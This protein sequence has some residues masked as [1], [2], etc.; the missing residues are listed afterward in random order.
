MRSGIFLLLILLSAI[1]L[2]GQKLKYKDIQEQLLASDSMTIYPVLKAFI[3]QDTGHAHA[4][5]TLARIFSGLAKK[6]DPIREFNN[7]IK[8]S[9]SALFYFSKCKRLLTEKEIRKNSD[10]YMFL[11]TE[12]ERKSKDDEVILTNKITE[13]INSHILFFQTHLRNIRLIF[14]CFSRASENYAFANTHYVKINTDFNS[15]KELYLIAGD[16]LKTE[17]RKIGSSYDSTLTYLNL[18]KKTLTDYPIKNF[19]PSYEV[20]KIE[21]FRLDGLSG[22]EF[23][24]DKILLWN[25]SEWT[26]AF[27][28]II[29]SDI[30]SLREKIKVN[31]EKLNKTASLLSEGLSDTVSLNKMDPGLVM[32]LNKY[33]FNS[34]LINLLSYKEQK[35]DLLKSS[36]HAFNSPDTCAQ[37]IFTGKMNFFSRYADLINEC[38]STLNLCS[39][40][41]LSR[42]IKKHSAY[43]K[44]YQSQEG[45]KKYIENEIQFIKKEKAETEKKYLAFTVNQLNKFSDAGR[46][47]THNKSEFPLFVTRGIHNTQATAKF[48]KEDNEGNIYTA[49]V[50]SNL[51]TKTSDVYIARIGKSKQVEWF[52]TY[53]LKPDANYGNDVIT[54]LQLTEEG[55]VASIYTKNPLASCNTILKLNKAG[56]E[57]LIKKIENRAPARKVIY[58]EINDNYILVFKGDSI[59]ENIDMVE[60][61]SIQ[62]LDMAGLTI[63]SINKRIKGRLED[64][65][66]TSEGFILVA[67]F[68]EF[69]KED[70]STLK[71]S[72]P[73][74]I[75]VA[76]INFDGQLSKYKVQ[77]EKY[78][79]AYLFRTNQQIHL[80]IGNKDEPFNAMNLQSLSLLTFSSVPELLRQIPKR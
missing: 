40:A 63:R 51:T 66:K 80:L 6:S 22:S 57:V 56:N 8:L 67:H 25:Y 69:E 50:M 72:G 52:K 78:S 74:N 35:N 1:P 62:F 76:K 23:L 2:L 32:L 70:F 7:S 43:F 20:R 60:T 46:Y 75:L 9:D 21:T 61:I 17:L 24:A 18:L 30:K 77:E 34:F 44:N 48:I 79:A 53:D 5:F 33:D 29:E 12:E 71:T 14:N 15:L 36:H 13:N 37:K 73:L 45:L 38:D 58:D 31:E 27:F 10:M 64:V 59:E 54:S 47:F 39:N 3:K 41:D 19:N 68:K 4:H 16:S 55:C 49:G 65:I 42:E 26:N 28:K 11:L